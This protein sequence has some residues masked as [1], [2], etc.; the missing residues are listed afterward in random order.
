MRKEIRRN[1]I[2]SDFQRSYADLSKFIKLVITLTEELASEQQ[3][4]CQ[5]EV[6]A[7]LSGHILGLGFIVQRYD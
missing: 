4:D 5:V 1:T 6:K 3:P 2:F 7:V